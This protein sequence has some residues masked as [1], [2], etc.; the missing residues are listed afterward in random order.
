M[1]GCLQV[2]RCARVCVRVGVQEEACKLGSSIRMR[3]HSEWKHKLCDEMV[4]WGS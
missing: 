1:S 2:G 4:A 3:T